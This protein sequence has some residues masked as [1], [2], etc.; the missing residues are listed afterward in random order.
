MLNCSRK[1]RN[2]SL[3]IGL[4]RMSSPFLLPHTFDLLNYSI[5]EVHTLSELE[6]EKCLC[7]SLSLTFHPGNELG[8]VL[9]ICVTG[10]VCPRCLRRG[11]IAQFWSKTDPAPNPG[12]GIYE[13][14]GLVLSVGSPICKMGIHSL[15]HRVI[16][17][18]FKKC[19]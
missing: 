3:F 7:Y 19:M 15:C 1:D 2:T 9:G 10:E 17:R 5:F 14:C 11:T 12:C 18:L 16:A 6:D 13:L 8:L 4:E